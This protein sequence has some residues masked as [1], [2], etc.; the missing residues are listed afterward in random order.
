MYIY[1]LFLALSSA[2]KSFPPIVCNIF[3]IHL[4]LYFDS[5]ELLLDIQLLIYDCMGIGIC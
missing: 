3:L 5:M 2:V 1:G 4:C